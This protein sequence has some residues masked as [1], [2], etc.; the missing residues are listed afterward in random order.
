MKRTSKIERKTSETNITLALDIDSCGGFD[1]TSGIGFF[2]HMLSAFAKH[3]RFGITLKCDGD[4]HIDGHHTVEDVGIVLGAAFKQAAG[5][6]RGI[7]RFSDIFMP[8]DETLVLAALDISGRGHLRYDFP[9]PAIKTG[10]FDI[11]LSREFFQSFVRKF[12][13]TLHLK[14]IHGENIHHIIEA[15]FKAAAVALRKALTVTGD[16]IPSSKGILV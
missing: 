11:Q 9:L 4:L 10:D 5:N 1:G 15:T 2:D 6:M 3:G 12:P 7:E 13:L 16:N 8:M 14:L